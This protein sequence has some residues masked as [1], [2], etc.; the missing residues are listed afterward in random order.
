[1]KRQL[2]TRHTLN[3]ILFVSR[4]F[5]TSTP[6]PSPTLTASSQPT[7]QEHLIQQL[8]SH[9]QDALKLIEQKDFKQGISSLIRIANQN[10][11]NANAQLGF[12]L[13]KGIEFTKEPSRAIFFLDKADQLG[14]SKI[15]SII[16]QQSFSFSH[17]KA[18]LKH[19]FNWVHSTCLEKDVLKIH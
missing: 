4:S 1:M 18:W 16:N 5:T 14:T 3:D 15:D 12:M 11:P 13:S 17:F 19:P 10:H 6:G 8:E 7:Q 2:K 9:Y